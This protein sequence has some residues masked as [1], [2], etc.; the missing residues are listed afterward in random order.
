MLDRT[1]VIFK[2]YSGGQQE[3]TVQIKTSLLPTQWKKILFE[4]LNSYFEAR[5]TS[6]LLFS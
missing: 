4:G 2:A 6:Y 1:A 5:K 3:K